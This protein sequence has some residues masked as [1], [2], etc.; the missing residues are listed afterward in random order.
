MANGAAIPDPS[1]SV[2]SDEFL[3]RWVGKEHITF[4]A[5]LGEYAIMS[6]RFRKPKFSV[7]RE[8]LKSLDSFRSEHPST[9]TARFK[10]EGCRVLGY[11]VEPD[12]LDSNPAHALVCWKGGSNKALR[13]AAKALR[14]DY[15][16]FIPAE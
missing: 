10:A 15:V 14:D 12:P 4:D 3:L 11:D 13:K 7:D 9:A 6:E 2:A 1:S 16:E 8:V 5:Q